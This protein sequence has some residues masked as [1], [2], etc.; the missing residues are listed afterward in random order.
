MAR[1]A[2]SELEISRNREVLGKHITLILLLLLKQFKLCSAL[3]AEYFAQLLVDSNFI[4]LALKML[5]IDQKSILFR[6]PDLPFQ[7]FTDWFISSVD[8]LEAPAPLSCASPQPAGTTNASTN[9][10]PRHPC[11]QTICSHINV[12]RILQKLIKGRT[13]RLR[14]LIQFRAHVALKRALG[15]RQPELVKYLMKLFQA[16][17]PFMPRKWRQTHMKIITTI[18]TALRPDLG[19]DWL[20]YQDPN[21]LIGGKE[22]AVIYSYNGFIILIIIRQKIHVGD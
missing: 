8:S 22:P 15:I 5:M 14:I 9:P 21:A 20:R 12:L 2:R 11:L 3:H 1:A 7:R 6:S 19:S 13:D 17:M 18:Y 4:L 16:M 10:S